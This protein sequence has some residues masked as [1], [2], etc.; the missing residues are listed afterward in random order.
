[1][2]VVYTHHARERMELRRVTTDMVE[3]TIYIPDQ[4]EQEGSS[5]YWAFKRYSQGLLKVVYVIKDNNHLIISTI[6]QEQ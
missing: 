4:V 2:T 5:K 3:E 1:M 6:W